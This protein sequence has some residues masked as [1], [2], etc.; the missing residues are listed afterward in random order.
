MKTTTIYNNKKIT[1]YH[2]ATYNTM[3]EPIFPV[4]FDQGLGMN[5]QRSDP[6]LCVGTWQNP[7]KISKTINE[8]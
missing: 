1:L 7:S 5:L 2:R 3:L 6:L 8:R 4:S